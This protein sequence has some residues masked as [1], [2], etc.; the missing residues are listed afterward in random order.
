MGEGSG[1]IV[2]LVTA[3]YKNLGRSISERLKEAGYKVVATYRSNESKA[4]EFSVESGIPIYNADLSHKGE[5]DA[6]FA[7]IEANHGSVGIVVNN[8]SSFP[9]GPLI[10]MDRH[11]F[12]DAFRSSVFAS[13]NV[14]KRSY[15]VMKEIKGGRIINIGMAGTDTVRPYI[16]VAAHASAKTALQVL[17]RSWAKELWKDKIT[18]NMVSPGIIDYSWRTDSWREKMRRLTICGSL[19]DPVKVAA[20]VL[21]FVRKADI[22]GLDLVV[23]P[24]PAY[25]EDP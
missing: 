20:S 13:N 22:S 6:L 21:Y 18:V 11:K 12:E 5:V 7:W 2:A 1:K 9:T 4:K 25:P 24:E 14:I 23:D 8:A 15:P 17:T 19:T 16:D 3:G 10:T